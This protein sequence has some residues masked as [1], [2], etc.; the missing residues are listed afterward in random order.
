M[1]WSSQ[2]SYFNHDCGKLYGLVVVEESTR[3]AFVVLIKFKDDAT[4]ELIA[5][6]E[7]VETI[8]GMKLHDHHSDGGG[9]FINNRFKEYC[10]SKGIQLT[11]TTAN[12]PFHNGIAERMNGALMEMARAMMIHAGAPLE[13]WGEAIT[14]AAFIHNNSVQASIGNQIPFKLLLGHCYPADKMR[15]FGC[16]SYIHLDESVR[17]KF[18]DKYRRGVFVGYDTTQ[19]GFRIYDPE[20]RRVTVSRNVKMIETSFSFIRNGID[21]EDR[22]IG[23]TVIVIPRSIDNPSVSPNIAGPKPNSGVTTTVDK[24]DPKE[25]TVTNPTTNVEGKMESKYDSEPDSPD[26]T[27]TNV[28]EISPTEG[29]LVPPAS[30]P[31]TV[32]SPVIAPDDTNEPKSPPL[33]PKKKQLSREV[34]QLQDKLSQHDK[35]TRVGRNISKPGTIASTSFTGTLQRAPITPAITRSGRQVKSVI[36]SLVDSDSDSDTDIMLITTGLDDETF[37][38]KTYKQALRSRAAPRWVQSMQEELSSLEANVL[39]QSSPLPKMN[40]LSLPNGFSKSN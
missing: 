4:D 29:H 35:P 31:P 14:Y 3:T 38:P 10:E 16:D 23:N 26:R 30:A 22:Y 8:T 25:E 36:Q 21:E 11:Y 27:T 34:R 5:I 37:E 28:N 12:S 40:R 13:L 17:G 15:V 18:Q 24:G 7:K 33:L 32:V 1:G 9:E 39:G 19:S 6:I 20:T 2:K